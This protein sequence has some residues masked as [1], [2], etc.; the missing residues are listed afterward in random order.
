MSTLH[1]GG[2]S[3]D[4]R[5]KWQEVLPWLIALA[6]FFLLPEYLNLGSRIL[7]FILFAMSLDL[8]VGYAGIVTLG[9]AAFFGLGA[10][11][12][13]IL[14]VRAGI[15]DPLIQLA[16]SAAAAGLLG[17]VTG[18]IILRT[19]G[20]ALMMLTLAIGSICLEVA[21]KASTITGGADGLAGVTIAPLLGQFRFDLYGK[22]AYLYCL[23]TLLICWWVVRR[24]VYSP[25]GASLAG[26][27]ENNLRM[28]AIGAP[29]YLRMLAVYSISAAL[30]GMAGA[31]LTQ[32]NQFVGLN[33][34]SFELSGEMLVMLI[35]GGVGR[36][37]GAFVGPGVYMIA[38]DQLAKQFP[39][40]WYL[41]I[42]ALL[43]IVVLFAKGGILGLLDRVLARIRKGGS[44]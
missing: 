10:Y 41:G 19:R 18:A 1:A 12:A 38:Q 29:V 42:G 27:R 3:A 13:G 44:L 35:L 21:N 31:L 39:E 43:V 15:N 30:A 4:S 33:V 25:F 5:L 22:T 23:V 9:H 17:T 26:I 32:T 14:S 24:L 7:I 20:L 11:T 34:L 6:A 2:Y 37:Y 40:Y 28:H 36:I 8:I 16:L